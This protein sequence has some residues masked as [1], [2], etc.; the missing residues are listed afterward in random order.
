[1]AG[2]AKHIERSHYSNGVNNQIFGG[3]EQKAS[4]K[5]KREAQKKY[6]REVEKVI[7]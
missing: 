7:Y 5:K 2:K 4:I 3:F 6:C 1:M